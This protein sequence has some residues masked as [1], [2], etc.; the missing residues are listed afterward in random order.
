VMIVLHPTQMCRNNGACTR[1]ARTFWGITYTYFT[2]RLVVVVEN[3]HGGL[4]ICG[5]VHC[6]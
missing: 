4:I 3:A 2:I 1:G 5:K 6:V